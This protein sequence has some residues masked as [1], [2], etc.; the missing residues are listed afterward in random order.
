[1]PDTPSP[2]KDH[3]L[4]VATYTL[5]QEL[6]RQFGEYIRANDER[7]RTNEKDIQAASLNQARID[8]EIMSMK[9][10]ISRL[11]E[12]LDGQEKTS[13]GMNVGGYIGIIIAGVI[14]WFK[15]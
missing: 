1:M 13:L 14:A 2:L 15:T 11:D 7:V 8:G 12:R 10:M 3:D 9:G 5:Q 6:S 4:L